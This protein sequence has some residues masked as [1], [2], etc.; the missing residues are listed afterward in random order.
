MKKLSK[1]GK[2]VL[3]ASMAVFALTCTVGV[4][5]SKSKAAEETW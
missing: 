2:V 4:G 1:K 5:M 3:A